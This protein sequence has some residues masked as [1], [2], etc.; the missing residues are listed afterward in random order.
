ML[1][2]W[3]ASSSSSVGM[4]VTDN[5]SNQFDHVW[6]TIKKVELLGA[7]GSITLFSDVSGKVVDLRALNV[8]GTSQ[9]DFIGLKSVP[10]GTYSTVSFTL[11][12]NLTVFP[13]GSPVGLP[14]GKVRPRGNSL[15]LHHN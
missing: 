12:E 5:I 14:R 4:F 11:D 7:G 8:N 3:V 13:T 1:R 10:P 15:A 2:V 9:F 6:V